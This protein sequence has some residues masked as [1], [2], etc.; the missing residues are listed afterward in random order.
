MSSINK[1]QKKIYH[2]F[3]GSELKSDLEKRVCQT[4]Y[5][6]EKS[7]NSL[8]FSNKKDWT[9]YFKINSPNFE[10]KFKSSGIHPYNNFTPRILA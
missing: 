7:Q 1:A 3:H 8:S 9:T 4:L 2:Y 6:N 10:A 5:R